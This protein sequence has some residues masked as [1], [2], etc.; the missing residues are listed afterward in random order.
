MKSMSIRDCLKNRNK[1]LS[2]LKKTLKYT[3]DVTS[4]DL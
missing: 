4:A 3:L 1:I 2:N